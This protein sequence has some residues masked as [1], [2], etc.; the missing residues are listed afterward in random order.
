MRQTHASLGK[1]RG[2][3]ERVLLV[4]GCDAAACGHPGGASGPHGVAGEP[5]ADLDALFPV[6]E[7]TTLADH[8]YLIDPL[9]NLMMRFPKDPDPTRTRKDLQKLLKASRIG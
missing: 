1:E 7:G 6:E 8:I 9:H 3:L 4:T 2:R 5:G